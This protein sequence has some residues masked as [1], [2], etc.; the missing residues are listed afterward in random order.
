MAD[1][2]QKIYP[3]ASLVRKVDRPSQPAGGN[4]SEN[5]DQKQIDA[6]K[7]IANA[8]HVE[9]CKKCKASFVPRR[10]DFDSELQ[11][12]K[13]NLWELNVD[14]YI[15]HMAQEEKLYATQLAAYRAGNEMEK[16]KLRE[17]IAALKINAPA[18]L[19]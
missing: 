19:G 14:V 11:T 15:A 10:D 1:I 13:E 16:V 2:H 7:D 4:S 6:L 8:L 12:L 18:K 5:N 17:Q 9:Q 3:L